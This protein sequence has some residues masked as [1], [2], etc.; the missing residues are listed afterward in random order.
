MKDHSFYLLL[1]CCKALSNFSS[2]KR[3]VLDAELGTQVSFEF[4]EHKNSMEIPLVVTSVRGAI[5]IFMTQ[6]PIPS[7]K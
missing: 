3:E 5:Y 7:D 6:Y 1:Y 4:K 2:Y